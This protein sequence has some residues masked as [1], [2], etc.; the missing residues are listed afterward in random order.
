[1]FLSETQNQKILIA[2]V[3]NQTLE[4]GKDL[5]IEMKIYFR[6]DR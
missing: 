4:I 5:G 6:E 3:I 2:K 1:M